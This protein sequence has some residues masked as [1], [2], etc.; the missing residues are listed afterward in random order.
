MPAATHTITIAR[1]IGE[2]FTFFADATNS[3]RWRA[4]VEE[5]TAEGPPAVGTVYRQRVTGPGGRS[6][7]ADVRITEFE[8][9]RRVV[10]EGISGPLRPVVE[11]TFDMVEGGTQVTFSLAAPLSGPKR[12]LMA[13]AVQRTMD[14]EV[15]GLD[16]AK[17]LLE[18]GGY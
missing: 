8:P 4:G 3:A 11:Y 6:V 5:I 7:S 1:P 10:L 16:H 14:T 17:T 2:V 9:E 18:S 12:L 13:R 15:A